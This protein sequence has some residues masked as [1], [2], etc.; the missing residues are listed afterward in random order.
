VTFSFAVSAIKDDLQLWQICHKL[1]NNALERAD[2]KLIHSRCAREASQTKNV[3]IK[4]HAHS[5]KGLKDSADAIHSQ[6]A[7]GPEM[8]LKPMTVDIMGVMTRR[9]APEHPLITAAASGQPLRIR[10]ILEHRQSTIQEATDSVGNTV[11]HIAALAGDSMILDMILHAIPAGKIS[12]LRNLTSLDMLNS[13]GETALMLAMRNGHFICSEI[14]V[15]DPGGETAL[16]H[17]S[18]LGMNCFF[19]ACYGGNLRIFDLLKDS[20]CTLCDSRGNSPLHAA[21]SQ[22]HVEV[23]RYLVGRGLDV[24]QT[25]QS[26]WTPLH[27]AACNGRTEACKELISLGAKINALGSAEETPC[28]LAYI[29]RHLATFVTLLSLGGEAVSPDA[30]PNLTKIRKDLDVTARNEI[31]SGLQRLRLWPSRFGLT[32]T[33]LA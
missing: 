22:G 12:G 18:N 17:V 6:T 8:W 9:Q 3:V 26:Q 27:W 1:Q 33:F 14:L 30:P 21:A 11:L 16:A 2:L 28:F 7:Y 29:R 32:R 5:I 25:N 20:P 4:S 24:N 31:V 15:N 10:R 23:I 19:F 13:R